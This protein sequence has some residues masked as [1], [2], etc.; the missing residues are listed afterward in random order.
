VVPTKIDKVG[1]TRRL[2]HY[3][4]LIAG[5]GLEPGIAF[6]PTSAVTGEGIAEARAW[7]R[8]LLAMQGEGAGGPSTG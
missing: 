1:R 3:R 5:L 4:E 8:A 6:L 2:R 7:I